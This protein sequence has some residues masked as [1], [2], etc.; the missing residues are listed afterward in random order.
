[1]APEDEIKTQPPPPNH[2]EDPLKTQPPQDVPQSAI[3]ALDKLE[4]SLKESM[5]ETI[6][7]HEEVIHSAL[8][9]VRTD[10]LG[11]YQRMADMGK[12]QAE[13]IRIL[14]RDLEESRARVHRIEK[15]CGLS[16]LL[17]D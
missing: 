15:H 1:M 10:L 3:L 8:N 2:D 11:E 12:A 17:D 6:A 13:D 14:R 5:R 16:S 7:K 4:S 9:H